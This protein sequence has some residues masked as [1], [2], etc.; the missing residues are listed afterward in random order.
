MNV[1][2]PDEKES[3][4]SVLERL[5][6]RFARVSSAEVGSEI[7]PWMERVA[8]SLGLDRSVIA[9]FLPER[10]GFQVLYQWTRE[11][12]P[13]MPMYFADDR[14]PWILAK[15]RA[16]ET[17]IVSSIHSLPRDASGDRAHMTSPDGSKAAVVVPFVI[18]NEIIGVIS[19][20]DLRHQRRWS[21]TLV[22]RLK[23][24]ADIFANALARQRST[25]QSNR[26]RERAESL[27]KFAV[28]GEMAAAV[29]H[30]LNHPLGAILANAQAARS[31]LGRSRPNLAKLNEIVDD[32]IS[33]ERRAS[34]Y[35][36]RVRGLFKD[37]RP[38]S[39]TLDITK[40]LEGMAALV[41]NDMLM[42][43]ISLKIDVDT[44]LPDV[45]ADR[46]GIEQVILNLLRNATDAV[47]IGDTHSRCIKLSAFRRDPG[48]VAIAVSDTGNG[49]DQKTLGS[50]FEPLFTTKEKG[51]GMGLTIVRSIVE[52][53]GGEVRIRSN[54]EQGTTFEFTLPVVGR[55]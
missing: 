28:L 9:E 41:Q 37:N 5:S 50:I 3:F 16:G 33:G 19:F 30:E 52:S 13:P 20:G 54:S 53:H 15:V 11:A 46:I 45:A 42:R 18:D 8:C 4:L 29:A 6:S 1:G 21:P 17:V 10:G 2:S 32:I 31:M 24:V 39:E 55:N 34:S 43:G 40:V 38:R 49:I 12:F 14:V 22:R 44:G 25:I 35:I 27:T 7:E 51:T 48:Q 23:V 26:M 47:T 36:E